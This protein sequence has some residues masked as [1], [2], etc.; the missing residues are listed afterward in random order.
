MSED[1]TVTW[2][3]TAAKLAARAAAARGVTM[4]AH[5]V[6]AE[7][8]PRT[9]MDVGDLRSSLVVTPATDHDPVAAV[10][11]DLPYAV[12]QHEN[13]AYRHRH[14]QAKFLENTLIAE[15]GNIERIIAA[16][17]RRALEGP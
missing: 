11:S 15:R 10:S 4:A 8:I 7:T 3:G 13:L 16:Q 14:G 9:P 6:Q 2:N 5:Q 12:E 17:T 1:V